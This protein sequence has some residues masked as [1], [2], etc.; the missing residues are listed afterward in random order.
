VPVLEYASSDEEDMAFLRKA[1]LEAEEAQKCAEEL[2]AAAK[3]R[4]NEIDRRKKA[5]EERKH[6]EEKKWLE[7]EKKQEADEREAKRIADAKAVEEAEAKQ[8]ADAKAA[9]DTEA[10]KVADVKAAQDAEG[11]KKAGE[12]GWVE[13]EKKWPTSKGKGRAGPSGKS[14]VGSGKLEPT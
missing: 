10:K 4:N 11:P 9:A 1:Q 13:A 5:C 2:A 12:H 6:E 14:R 3:L 7:A 8:V